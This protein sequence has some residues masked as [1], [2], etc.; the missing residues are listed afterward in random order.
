M[1]HPHTE[2]LF[3]FQPLGSAARFTEEICDIVRDT[4]L[5]EQL[6]VQ[7]TRAMC[8]FMNC[9]AAVRGNVLIY[10]GEP[11][12]SLLI[13]LTGRVAIVKRTQ[14]GGSVRIGSAGPGE[15]LGEMSLV[16]G[17]HRFASCIAEEPVDFA[18]LTRAALNEILMLHP[19]LGNK[20]LLLLLGHFSERLRHA[21]GAAMPQLV[22]CAV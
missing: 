8:G 13:V 5:F 11:G 17:Q 20:I 19:R 1:E 18:V 10:E 6:S 7:E 22:A 4:P 16:D 9:Y 15:A 12:N 14:D 21:I 2:S 3:R